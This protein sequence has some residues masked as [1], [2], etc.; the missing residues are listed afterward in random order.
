MCPPP[1]DPIRPV[2]GI[3]DT[4]RIERTW[5]TSRVTRRAAPHD[6]DGDGEHRHEHGAMHDQPQRR[7]PATDEP[8]GTYDDHGRKDEPEQPGPEGPHP[9]FDASA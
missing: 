4:D 7:P 3:S 5:S 1:S 2:R 6:Q 8:L 9:H